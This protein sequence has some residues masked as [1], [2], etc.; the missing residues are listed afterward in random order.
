MGYANN[1]FRLW[2][3]ETRSI[4]IPFHG[5]RSNETEPGEQDLVLGARSRK[6]ENHDA[7]DEDPRQDS[8][9]E[10]SS[11]DREQLEDDTL[12]Q[13]GQN[14]LEESVSETDYQSTCETEADEGDNDSDDDQELRRSKRDRKPPHWYSDYTAKKAI[15]HN[16]EIPQNIKDL[17][18]LAD[19]EEWRQALQEE[20]DALH[21]NET[22]TVVNCVPKGVKPIYSKSGIES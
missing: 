12:I 8:E 4:E 16:H 9:E 17:K 14:S 11:S 19:W 18:E 10:E 7:F 2:D 15:I 6:G 5:N 3:E 20:L 13:E 22:W 21:S 1:G